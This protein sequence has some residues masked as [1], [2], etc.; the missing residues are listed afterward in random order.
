MLLAP[1]A[2]NESLRST[3]SAHSR[4]RSSHETSVP[5]WLIT[6]LVG[7][8]LALLLTPALRGGAVGG[9]TLPFWLVVAPLINIVWLTWARSMANRGKA[10]STW[11][12]TRRSRR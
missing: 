4:R 8:A 7:G 5:A 9:W 6:W 10:T 11:P 12:S 3:R 2:L 1:F